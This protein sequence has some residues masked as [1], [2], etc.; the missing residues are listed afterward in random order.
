MPPTRCWYART[1]WL[2]ANWLFFAERQR[3]RQRDERQ[4][5]LERID[6]WRS[7]DHR[8][9]QRKN[10][11]EQDRREATRLLACMASRYRRAYISPLWG[12]LSFF[13]ISF[14]STPN[15]CGHWTELNQ[16]RTHIHLWKIW[17]EL[18]GQFPPQA[19]GQKRCLGPTLVYCIPSCTSDRPLPAC[20]ISLKS[21]NF[22]WTD[23][24][25][26]GRTFETGFIR[27]T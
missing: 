11:D 27:S 17:S 24:P 3:R 15:L 13:F 9:R 12:F 25:M 1:L 19:G 4:R 22:L 2:S 23:G 7:T 10:G 20:Q 18:P 21:K 26:H 16:T 6:A 14:F 5:L 8:W